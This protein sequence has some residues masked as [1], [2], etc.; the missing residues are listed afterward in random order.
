MS[1]KQRN[2]VTEDADRPR[3]Q[4]R[5]WSSACPLLTLSGHRWTHILQI[6]VHPGIWLADRAI[7]RSSVSVAVAS[8]AK[9]GGFGTAF[10]FTV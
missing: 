9:G 10:Q 7:H 3:S 1:S 2:I 4:K 8:H 5:A 6:R